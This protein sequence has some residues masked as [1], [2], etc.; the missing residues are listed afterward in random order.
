M[1]EL[2]LKLSTRLMRGIAAKFIARSIR[3][4]YGYKVNV[5]LNELNINVV[6][7]DA[8]IKTSVEVT[9]DNREFMEI[10]KNIM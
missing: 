3:K 1:D 2:K 10:M 7:G 4:K 9:I 6:D 8:T 5:Q